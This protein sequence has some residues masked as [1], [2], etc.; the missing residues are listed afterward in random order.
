MQS[1]KCTTGT[2]VDSDEGDMVSEKSLIN[3]M[4]NI[5]IMLGYFI[6]SLPLLHCGAVKMYTMLIV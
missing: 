5:K 3:S 1:D 4:Y 2:V 6:C